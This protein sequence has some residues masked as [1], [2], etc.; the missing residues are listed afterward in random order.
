MV[1]SI[2]L[3][4]RKMADIGAICVVALL[5]DAG[6]SPRTL[7][8][9]HLLVDFGFVVNK[10][11]LR[12]VFL[13]LLLFLSVFF[14][15]TLPHIPSFMCHWRNINFKT[16]SVATYPNWTRWSLYWMQEYLNEM[17]CDLFSRAFNVVSQV[18]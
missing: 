10:V 4:E 15:P 6:Y 11:A 7:D 16:D 5:L 14:T 13:L 2:G 12:Q 18:A 1:K 17:F 9:S 3:R 8:F